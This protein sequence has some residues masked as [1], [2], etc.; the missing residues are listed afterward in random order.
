MSTQ[1]IPE[2][3]APKAC[4]YRKLPLISPWAY[5]TP[6]GALGGLM[7]GEGAYILGAYNGT[8]KSFSKQVT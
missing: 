8:E 4:A 7:T 3:A 5:T 6:Y 1:T 2:I